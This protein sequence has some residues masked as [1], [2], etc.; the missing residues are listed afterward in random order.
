MR[1]NWLS[2]RIFKS[3]EDILHH[4]C[5]IWNKLIISRMWIRISRRSFGCSAVDLDFLRQ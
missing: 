2:K 3:Y 1:D 5:F 4:C